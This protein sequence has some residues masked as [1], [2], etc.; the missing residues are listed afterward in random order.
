MKGDIR[1]TARKPRV[2]DV[3]AVVDAYLPSDIDAW[4]DN[5]KD[6]LYECIEN[7]IQQTNIKSLEI[8][9]VYC[10]NDGTLWRLHVVL[11][12]KLGVEDIEVV[13]LQ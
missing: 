1:V 9:G 5:A 13:T 2:F 3:K 11:M 8:I 6:M 7:I 4:P 12:E 10:L